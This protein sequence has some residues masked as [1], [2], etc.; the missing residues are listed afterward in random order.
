[1]VKPACPRTSRSTSCRTRRSS[2][3][4]LPAGQP[5]AFREREAMPSRRGGEPAGIPPNAP[6]ESKA[7]ARFAPEASPR[8]PPGPESLFGRKRQSGCCQAIPAAY[9]PWGPPIAWN[10]G[11]T[12]LHGAGRPAPGSTR[13]GRS[14]SRALRKAE[15]RRSDELL[16]A[17]STRT[18]ATI[19]ETSDRR[20]PRGQ[21]RPPHRTPP[22]RV[23]SHPDEASH[24]R[25]PSPV[26]TPPQ[27]IWYPF[28][29][30]TEAMTLRIDRSRF[31]ARAR[32]G[33]GPV[34]PPVA[35]SAGRAPC[36]WPRGPCAR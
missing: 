21:I 33:Q 26:R 30:R 22:P 2:G 18:R 27:P 9:P 3:N 35:R 25:R 12:A 16:P 32:F 28:P 5:E 4:P 17:G 19:Q 29:C 34:R 10:E 24:S 31:P 14:A 7:R 23:R 36:G 6:S 1:M 11:A 15:A 20:P 8:E 13:A